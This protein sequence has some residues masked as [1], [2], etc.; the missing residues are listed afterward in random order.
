MRHRESNT[1]VIGRHAHAA[2]P[3][4]RDARV[5]EEEITSRREVVN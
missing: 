4:S 1:F 5:V 3:T 2:P